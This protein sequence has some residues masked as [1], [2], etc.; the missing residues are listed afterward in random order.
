MRLRFDR[1]RVTADSAPTLRLGFP[2]GAGAGAGERKKG[3]AKYRPPLAR[4][5]ET[6]TH[7]ATQERC[8]SERSEESAFVLSIP[9]SAKLP[10][11]PQSGSVSVANDLRYPQKRC[12]PE[13]SEGSAV[14]SRQSE[15]RLTSES[16]T[17]RSE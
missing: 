1:G 15:S 11:R 4:A 16:A 6:G 17:T 2:A 5:T 8:H 3:I 7:A 14:A 13:R 12:H 10:N 9:R